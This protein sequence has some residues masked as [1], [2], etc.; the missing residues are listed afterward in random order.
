[1]RTNVKNHPRTEDTGGSSI[2]V[3][4]YPPWNSKGGVGEASRV[5]NH[6]REHSR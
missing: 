1:V 2:P 3:R 5:K 4:R 6:P